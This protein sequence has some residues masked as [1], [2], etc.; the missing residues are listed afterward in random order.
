MVQGVGCVCVD[1]PYD[2]T[3]LMVLP[4]IRC[5]P[6]KHITKSNMVSHILPLVASQGVTRPRCSIYPGR[7]REAENK[8]IE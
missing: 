1:I 4:Y 7:K 2:N 3:H 5:T 6:G 8:E